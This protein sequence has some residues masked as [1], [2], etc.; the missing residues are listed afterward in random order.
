[1]APAVSEDYYMRFLYEHLCMSLYDEVAYDSWR[2]KK[3]NTP[4]I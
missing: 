3:E 1:M 4:T 2:E